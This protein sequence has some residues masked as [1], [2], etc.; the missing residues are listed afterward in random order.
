MWRSVQTTIL[1]VSG[2][3][4]GFVRLWD[5]TRGQQVAEIQTTAKVLSVAFSRLGDRVVAGRLDGTIDILDDRNLQ[6]L[7][8]FA[9]HPNAP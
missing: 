1:F 5:I 6:P 2:G 9:A 7:A 3:D 8:T 4:D